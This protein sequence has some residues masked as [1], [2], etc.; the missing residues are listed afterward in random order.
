MGPVEGARYATSSAARPIAD[1][2][3][4]HYAATPSPEHRIHTILMDS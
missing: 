1:T 3:P 4:A 2:R